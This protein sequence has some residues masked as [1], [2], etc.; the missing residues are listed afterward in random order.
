MKKNILLIDIDSVI[1]NLA[2]KKCEIYHKGICDS[3][4]T[5]QMFESWADKI[6]VSTVFEW[7]KEKTDHWKLNDRAIIGGTGHDYS[8]KLPKEID[9]IIPKINIGFTTRGCIRKCD[10]CF[11]PK[12]EGMIRPVCSIYEIWDGKS[13]ELMLLDNNILALPG[14]FKGICSQIRKEK[15]RVDFNQGLDLRLLYANREILLEELQ[16]IRHPEYKFAWDQDDDS[17]VSKLE[18]LHDNL[19]RCTVYVYQEKYPY[20]K[21]MWKLNELKRMGHNAH[22]MLHLS[23]RDDKKYKRLRSWAN[24]HALFQGMSFDEYCN[25]SGKIDKT[26]SKVKRKSHGEVVA[27]ESIQE[28]LFNE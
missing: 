21:I 23:L 14:H 18:W 15:L 27:P 13:K 22:L 25:S 26:L 1:P 2:L 8:V 3:V 20:E 5:S 28:G 12:M 24:A 4:E 19:G 9:E 17:M 7:S 11:V 16:T 6:Y 10:F